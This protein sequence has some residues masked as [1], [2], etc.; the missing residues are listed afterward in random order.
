MILS[1]QAVEIEIR[2]RYQQQRCA[3]IGSIHSSL[4][5]C[6]CVMLCCREACIAVCIYFIFVSEERVCNSAHLSILKTGGRDWLVILI[7]IIYY[8]TA[9]GPR[10][11]CR[12]PR[13]CRKIPPVRRTVLRRRSKHILRRISS[14]PA[15]TNQRSLRKHRSFR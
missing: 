4:V 14:R 9:S 7:I 11:S 2:L 12:S 1:L 15:A 5:L 13:S 3:S 6:V 8:T 10:R